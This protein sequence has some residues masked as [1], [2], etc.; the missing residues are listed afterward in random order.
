MSI[1]AP[2]PVVDTDKDKISYGVGLEM[3]RNL[4]KQDIDVNLD[5]IIRG[6]QDGN[7][8]G[9]RLWPDA[10]LRPLMRGFQA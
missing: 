3:S 2:P 1:S 5:L 7:S 9:N 4:K 6:L 10:E 8:G